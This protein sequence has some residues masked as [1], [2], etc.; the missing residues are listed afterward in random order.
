MHRIREVS[1]GCTSVFKLYPC[2]QIGPKNNFYR[3][4]LSSFKDFERWSGKLVVHHKDLARQ[5]VCRDDVIVVHESA[6]D[7]SIEGSVEAV[8]DHLQTTFRLVPVDVERLSSIQFG[9]QRH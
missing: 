6:D 4:Y 5:A 2:R 7:R 9:R 8:L 3:S 1:P